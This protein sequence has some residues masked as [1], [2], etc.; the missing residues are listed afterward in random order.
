MCCA[1]HGYSNIH[2]GD[3]KTLAQQH[4]SMQ[5][6]FHG[7][8][9]SS[10][11][12]VQMLAE[13]TSHYKDLYEMGVVSMITSKVASKKKKQEV[14]RRHLKITL[15]HDENTLYYTGTEITHDDIEKIGKEESSRMEDS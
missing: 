6:L 7:I 15:S 13:G 9:G 11:S 10:P 1:L 3:G 8:N 5:Q 12:Q 2:E 4:S 14:S